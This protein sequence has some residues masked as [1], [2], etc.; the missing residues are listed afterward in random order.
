MKF[1]LPFAKDATA[2]EH[3]YAAIKAGAER[4]WGPL[5]PDRYYAIRYIQNG[6]PICNAVGERDPQTR[7]TVFAIFRPESGAPFLVCTTNRGVLS[8]SAMLA[9]GDA[10]ATLFDLE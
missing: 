5:L 1:F 6:K 2:A 7:E 10:T 4:N 3:N 8:G 9:S